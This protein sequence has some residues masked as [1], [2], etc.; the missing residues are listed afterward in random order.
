MLSHPETVAAAPVSP[1]PPAE[2]P[3]PSMTLRELLDRTG[4]AIRKALPA[5]AWVEASVAKVRR[6]ASG[7]QLELVEAFAGD[8]AKAG[9]LTGFLPHAALT[10][11]RE[12]IGFELDPLTLEGTCAVLKVSVSFHGHY[13]LQGRISALNPAQTEDLHAKYLDA[14]QR[15]LT[16]EGLADHQ[17]RLPAPIDILRIA[18]IHPEGA[19]GWA[20]VA[21]EL[22]RLAERGV[23]TFTS[24]PATF[25]GTGARGSLCAAFAETE[26]IFAEDGL[27]LVLLVRGGGAAAGLRTLSDEAIARALCAMPVPV[28][29]GLGHA[30][31]RSLLDELAWKAMDTPSKAV[32]LVHQIL[33]RRAETV[34]KDYLS[35][36]SDSRRLIERQIQPQMSRALAALGGAVRASLAQARASIEADHKAIQAWRAR[37]ALEVEALRQDLYRSLGDLIHDV[38]TVPSAKQT[39]LT[40]GYRSLL[41][42][43]QRACKS[44]DKSGAQ[45]ETMGSLAHDLLE[46][47]RQAV[48]GL[49]Q[50]LLQFASRAVCETTERLDQ[51]YAQVDALSPQATLRRGYTVALDRDR[52]P[53]TC[54][55]AAASAP[56]T[57][58]LSGGSVAAAVETPSASVTS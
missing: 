58:V 38:R 23:V 14:V 35:L 30:N 2:L 5:Q 45:A 53:I 6:T 9:R 54:P 20:D 41:G 10:R 22:R 15:R 24:L 4:Q 46:R 28:V 48:I 31:D 43:F 55:V 42:G 36:L 17:K 18:V 1:D 11:I 52:R 29:T 7:Y 33:R 13:H 39:D 27:D 34:T 44:L 25:E 51:L 16:A 49:H 26:R 56:F 40:R 57:L 21:T 19:A 50:D 37:L 3:I 12:E 47:Q 32:G 8:P